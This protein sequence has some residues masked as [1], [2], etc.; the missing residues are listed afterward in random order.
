MEPSFVVAGGT[1]CC[2]D[3]LWCHQGWQSGLY[4]SSRL[5]DIRVSA[6]VLLYD[7]NH[8]VFQTS[9]YSALVIFLH[10]VPI[11]HPKLSKMLPTSFIR[12]RYEVSF[13]GL[14]IPVI[15]KPEFWFLLPLLCLI[16]CYNDR[17]ISKASSNYISEMNVSHISYI[18]LT[19]I[20]SLP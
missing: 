18:I 14:W 1:A 15:V 3:N 11:F 19:C 10:L 20:I 17:D 8:G 12:A 2:H 16:S 7:P 5:L 6:W 13:C 4:G 9:S